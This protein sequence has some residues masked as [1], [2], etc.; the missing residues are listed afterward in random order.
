MWLTRQKLSF[1]TTVYY[2]CH[3]LHIIL[4]LGLSKAYIKI[5]IG[6]ERKKKD[7]MKYIE[8]EIATVPM[9][10]TVGGV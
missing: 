1:S 5:N 4:N 2:C 7:Y 10:K 9:G 6:Y 3:I 8:S